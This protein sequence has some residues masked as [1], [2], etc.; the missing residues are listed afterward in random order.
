[1]TLV[2]VGTGRL[3][4]AVCYSLATLGHRL[5]AGTRVLVVGRRPGPAAE[6]CH[7]AS[8]RA[9]VSG[10]SGGPGAGRPRFEPVVGDPADVVTGAGVRGV[11]VCASAQSP[12]ERL[13]TPSAWTELVRRARFG[14]TLP[15]QA[16]PALRVARAAPNGTWVVNACFPDAVNPLLAAL[17]VPVLC[18]AGNV[19]LLAAGVQA[20][21]DLPDQDRLRLVAHHLHLYPPDGPGGE[22]LAWLDDEPV[23]PTPLLAGQRAVARDELNHV[24]GHTAALLV[25][26]LLTGT[27]LRTNLPG[28]HGL[29]GG[30]PV[31]VRDAGVG[32]RLPAG[33]TR[34]EAV[35]HN[36]RWAL[37]DGA[38]VDGGRVTFGDAARA[39]LGRTAPELADGFAVTDLAAVT[40]RLHHLR[41]Q[42]RD[43]PGDR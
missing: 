35:A 31:T 14:I 17:G 23:D 7:I 24:T 37:A 5:P 22:A 39:E 2:V 16:E 15:L 43:Q 19:G 12:W 9:A 11:L 32:L 8:A 40:E 28:P 38:V 18:G 25:A 4:R 42:L 33:L 36:Q 6:L 27:E 10:V 13:A 1:V 3:A 29:P 34:D 21:L 41:D 20:A 26:A 30:Y